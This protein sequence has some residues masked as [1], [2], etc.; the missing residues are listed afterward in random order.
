[1]TS[2]SHHP[3][4][5]PS[6]KALN[7]LR[8]SVSGPFPTDKPSAPPLEFNLEVIES[9]PTTD[10]LKTI[11]SYLPSKAASPSLVFLSTHP[12]AAERPDTVSGIVELGR[13]N[14]NALKWPIVVDWNDGKASVGDVEGVKGILE[15]LRK[16]RDGELKDE[17][18]DQPK[19]W[20]S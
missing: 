14:P 9:T 20:F 12:S 3:S 13:K 10:Q 11:L 18:V 16:K 19:G 2:S 8:A 6:I 1:M 4:S 15:I 5:P 7:I 17:E